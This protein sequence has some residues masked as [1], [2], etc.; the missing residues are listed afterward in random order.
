M[1][2]QDAAEFGLKDGDIVS[3]RVDS[4]VRPLIF[5]N[6]VVRVRENFSLAM[7]IDTDEANAAGIVPGMTGTIVR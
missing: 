5:G 4:E 6:V 1:T 3:V 2:P 7:H